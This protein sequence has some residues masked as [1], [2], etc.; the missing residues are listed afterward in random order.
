MVLLKPSKPSGR[1]YFYQ[2]GFF[3]F[4]RL[5]YSWE[6]DVLVLLL[7]IGRAF[8]K[9]GWKEIARDATYCALCTKKHLC[10]TV[11][12]EKAV[13]VGRRGLCRL[14]GVARAAPSSSTFW[15]CVAYIVEGGYF[16]K[17]AGNAPGGIISL[18]KLARDTYVQI[19][20]S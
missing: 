4:K 7:L 13:K 16:L 2:A 18:A 20:S 5:A 17:A 1:F 11:M 19:L 8:L 6:W 9:G 14:R 15:I 3:R 12:C 10:L